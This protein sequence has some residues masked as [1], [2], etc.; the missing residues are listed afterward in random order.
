MSVTVQSLSLVLKC[1]C[2][3]RTDP[4]VQKLN[5]DRKSPVVDW[6]IKMKGI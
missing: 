5:K 3:K 2:R 1:I 6:K 4:L